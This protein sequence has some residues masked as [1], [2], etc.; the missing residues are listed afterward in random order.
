MDGSQV[1]SKAWDAVF[2]GMPMPKSKSSS[3]SS[4]SSTVNST[5]TKKMTT[6][7]SRKKKSPAL[8]LTPLA[9]LEHLVLRNVHIASST[10]LLRLFDGLAHH[11]APLRTL[12]CHRLFSAS[13]GQP[14]YEKLAVHLKNSAFPALSSL[15]L[16]NTNLEESIATALIKGMDKGCR[17][18]T[19]LS[20]GRD[21]VLAGHG[22]DGE[23]LLSAVME[24][25]AGTVKNGAP[26]HS[27]QTL[28]LNLTR[29]KWVARLGLVECIL[30][31]DI[32]PTTGMCLPRA[33][34]IRQPD[35]RLPFPALSSL[36]LS[37]V[38]MG[39]P[40]ETV[41]TLLQD[42]LERGV[43]DIDFSKNG[44]D[45]TKIEELVSHLRTLLLRLPSSL[46]ISYERPLKVSLA[47]WICPYRRP[48]G[49]V[50]ECEW[51]YQ[52]FK[53][54]TINWPPGCEVLVEFPYSLATSS[55]IGC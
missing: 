29:M 51:G 55:N 41:K 1:Q 33:Q 24:I 49:I 6:T 2:A 53:A 7:V 22:M 23:V 19:C 15:T 21:P 10:T 36:C 38:L 52:E 35:S 37:R 18:V 42:A 9:R 28:R 17:A 50:G 12:E 11:K 32:D 47:Q 30:D 40:V 43:R 54:L 13:V 45:K 31:R 27:L 8:F 48:W 16:H 14:A 3:S 20:L 26:F 25:A 46:S 44:W 39:L 4:S 34:G 5:K